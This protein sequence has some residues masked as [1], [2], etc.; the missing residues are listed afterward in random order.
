[1][2]YEHNRFALKAASTCDLSARAAHV[3]LVLAV[4]ADASGDSH[5]SIDTL[6][7]DSRRN[8]HTIIDAIAE[9]EAAGVLAVERRGRRRGNRY[10][11][12][13]Q[14]I[15]ISAQAGTKDHPSFSASGATNRS[16]VGAEIDRFSAQVGTPFSAQVG[17]ATTPELLRELRAPIDPAS[18]ARCP[19]RVDHRICN[20]DCTHCHGTGHVAIEAAS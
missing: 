19:A 18:F 15:L 17:T 2:S 3:L 4:R 5:P 20:D 8:R 7:R 16:T 6:A 9:L 10:T 1:V 12:P 14:P 13:T 11:V